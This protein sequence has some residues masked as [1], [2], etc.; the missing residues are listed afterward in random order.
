M[1]KVT[2]STPA[3]VKAEDLAELV[4]IV[5]VPVVIEPVS[6]AEAVT[7]SKTK[8]AKPAAV[9]PDGERVKRTYKPRVKKDA[10]PADPVPE[11]GDTPEAG[12]PPAPEGT[13]ETAVVS[14]E[15]P[16]KAAAKPAAKA[17][18]KPA[19]KKAATKE[20]PAADPAAKLDSEELLQ[21]F[22]LLIDSN[23]DDALAVL[24]GFGASSFGNLKETE[25]PAFDEKLK[26]LGF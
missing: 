15:K 8:A 9:G 6:G 7:G 21:R 18:A 25:W 12:E 16:V 5:G 22:S 11:A 1:F 23:Y 20:K 2:L 3:V 26:E 24:E 10:P 13:V 17:A 4:R 19:A 14:E